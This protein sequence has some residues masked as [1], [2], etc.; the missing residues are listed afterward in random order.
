MS[1]FFYFID[2][3]F[4]RLL[5]VVF[6]CMLIRVSNAQDYNLGLIIDA[7]LDNNVMLLDSTY[8]IGEAQIQFS[9]FK[10]Y[11]SNP[12]FFYVGHPVKTS[13]ADFFLIDFGTQERQI[14]FPQKLD[15]M[16][17]SISFLLG[18]D[19]L[20]NEQGVKGGAL[21]PLNGMY[22]T[23]RTGYINLKIEG[24]LRIKGGNEQSF[25]Y[26]LGGFLEPYA[27]DHY[28]GFQINKP[29]S[30]V[31]LNLDFFIKY[32]LDSGSRLIMSPSE[33]SNFL[34]KEFTEHFEILE[35]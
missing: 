22:W 10:F 27:Q 7:R 26:H 5:G 13:R 30:G 34:L 15:M 35:N 28:F 33:E 9:K 1:P 14:N 12:S 8:I 16:P 6:I 21:D 24:S 11:L 17:D 19:S 2:M 23:W 3:N 18:V 31:Y 4:L 29:F 32:L 20:I 25:A